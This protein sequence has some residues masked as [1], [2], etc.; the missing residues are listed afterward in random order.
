[1]EA[2]LEGKI[3]HQAQK[4]IIVQRENLAKK[5]SSV[6][7]LHC[8]AKIV[9]YSCKHNSSLKGNFLKMYPNTTEQRHRIFI[10][11]FEHG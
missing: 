7:H 2:K 10:T 1:M 3:I 8:N 4:M 9:K 5:L 6:A 11:G